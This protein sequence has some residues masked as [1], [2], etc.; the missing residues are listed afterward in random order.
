MRRCWPLH[1]DRQWDREI[2]CAHL[3]A[4][5]YA[6]ENAS[7]VESVMRT[8]LGNVPIPGQRCEPQAIDVQVQPR[9]ELESAQHR[10]DR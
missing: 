8:G 6:G 10:G 9:C 7:V 1:A 2:A 3:S 5:Q 4:G